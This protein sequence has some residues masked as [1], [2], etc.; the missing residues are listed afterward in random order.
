[1]ANKWS[2]EIKPQ[3]E[4]AFRS[5]TERYDRVKSRVYSAKAPRPVTPVTSKTSMVRTVDQAMTPKLPTGMSLPS[6]DEAKPSI[7]KSVIGKHFVMGADSALEGIQGKEMD[8]EAAFNNFN[9]SRSE[10][11]VLA[12]FN[13]ALLRSGTGY[14]PEIHIFC[15]VDI[16]QRAES[17]VT[18]L[19][20]I[21]SPLPGVLFTPSSMN[22]IPVFKNN[23]TVLS[24]DELVISRTERYADIRP[25][26]SPTSIRVV[27]CLQGSWS[28]TGTSAPSG[29]NGNEMKGSGSDKKD[30]DDAGGDEGEDE[31]SG[32][33]EG[34]DGN[35]DD[36]E[37]DDPTDGSS[38]SMLPVVS[39]ETQAKV[40]A[41]TADTVSPRVFQQLQANGR[42]IIKVN[43]IL[44]Y[45]LED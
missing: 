3:L 38:I 23:E 28:N 22:R 45:L 32:D 2:Q 20:K 11:A 8:I 18:K 36:E 25:T 24:W 31:E 9:I 41:N 40:Y 19:G 27:S 4:D 34:D 44:F 17:F 26:V 12:G 39:F 30:T 21:L 33:H 15:S 37:P 43:R 35:P 29:F 42:L 14:L 6:K 7:D 1:M 5:D 10:Y 16:T 13:E